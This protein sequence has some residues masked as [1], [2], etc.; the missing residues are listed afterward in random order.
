[1]KIPLEL[2]I[3]PCLVFLGR[4]ESLKGLKTHFNHDEPVEFE[5]RKFALCGLGNLNFYDAPMNSG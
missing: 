2:P 5:R 1:M 4:E 3:S